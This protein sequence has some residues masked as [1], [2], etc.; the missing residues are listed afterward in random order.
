VVGFGYD[1]V[2]T[3]VVE[4][5]RARVRVGF[6]VKVRRLTPISQMAKGLYQKGPL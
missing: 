1:W 2:K 5:W 3:K 4:A 6:E